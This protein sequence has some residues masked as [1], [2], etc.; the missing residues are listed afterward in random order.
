MWR[1]KTEQQLN[2]LWIVGRV[3]GR[4]DSQAV[5]LST[6]RYVCLSVCLSVELA[7]LRN[8]PLRL[9]QTCWLRRCRK[10]NYSNNYLLITV[11]FPTCNICFVS[12]LKG[13]LWKW[14]NFP[15]AGF[16]GIL[17]TPSLEFSAMINR[18]TN[19]LVLVL[20]N[21]KDSNP[22]SRTH[23]YSR[24]T[25]RLPGRPWLYT[26]L[27]VQKRWLSRPNLRSDLYCTIWYWAFWRSAC[28]VHTTG[29]TDIVV[30]S[31]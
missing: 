2:Q 10:K 13:L 1:A 17:L 7:E 5:D 8:H 6:R 31:T 4:T 24:L 14:I 23:E 26:L 19:F 12:L 18:Q 22:G 30:E 9:M 29:T 27:G 15:T 16:H 20:S 3:D 28:R 21:W 11:A 25:T